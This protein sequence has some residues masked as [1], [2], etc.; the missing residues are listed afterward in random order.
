[1]IRKILVMLLFVTS[2]VCNAQIQNPVKWSFASRSTGV[3]EAELVLT[4][5]I[6]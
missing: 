4:A 5:M 2:I 1:M 6:G 3:G